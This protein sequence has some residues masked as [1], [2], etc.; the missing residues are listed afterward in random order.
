MDRSQGFLQLMRLIVC[1]MVYVYTQEEDI[2]V[3]SSVC[4][5]GYFVHFPPH[6]IS[7]CYLAGAWKRIVLDCWLSY[8]KLGQVFIQEDFWYFLLTFHISSGFK[9]V[10]FS[11]EIL[12][13]VMQYV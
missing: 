2:W 8:L 6:V 10:D 9:D 7:L 13:S 12:V 3:E 4:V 5:G 11:T 1:S